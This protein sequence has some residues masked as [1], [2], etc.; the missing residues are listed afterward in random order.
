M[1]RHVAIGGDPN[2]IFS[3]GVLPRCIRACRV[4][5]AAGKDH[6]PVK[7]LSCILD[8][9]Q[10]HDTAH[11]SAIFGRKSSRVNGHGLNVI[12]FHFIA[13]AWRKIV[14]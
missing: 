9:V 2:N 14:G 6:L 12:G 3:P 5:A 1:L 4:E 11:F 10:L 7:S 8:R 13:K